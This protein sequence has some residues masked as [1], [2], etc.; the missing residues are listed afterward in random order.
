MFPPPPF[1]RGY[2]E[3]TWTFD[4]TDQHLESITQTERVL[5]RPPLD[6]PPTSSA[7]RSA[8]LKITA[9][10]AT[11]DGRGAQVVVCLVEPT[12]RAE[13]PFH[14]VA[15]IYDPLYYNG[16]RMMDLL[17]DDGRLPDH[18]PN[19]LRLDERYRLKVLAMILDGVVRQVHAG[20]EQRD[21]APRNI[22]IM[23]PPRSATESSGDNYK[24]GSL[25]QLTV[26]RVVLIDYNI[27]RVSVK[28][29]YGQMAF[30]R[31]KLPPNPILYF[32]RSTLYEHELV[33]WLPPEWLE[34]PALR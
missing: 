3:G 6:G 27:A 31:A 4:P 2:P 16:V 28:M 8:R 12:T 5:E 19:A 25:Q 10:L 33:G 18:E 22:I 13:K 23:P 26:T 24:N 21:L 32:R 9:T 20:L 34:N 7:P 14:A 30:P 15:K 17:V 11:G 1:A 29:I